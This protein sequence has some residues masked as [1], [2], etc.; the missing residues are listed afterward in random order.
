MRKATQ[1]MMIDRNPGLIY[2]RTFCSHGPVAWI[3]RVSLRV[4]EE[5][6]TYRRH[7]GPLFHVLRSKHGYHFGLNK[8]LR[9]DAFYV[10]NGSAGKRFVWIDCYRV[11]LRD[12]I[13]S[14][15]VDAL[16]RLS[17][18]A[19]LDLGSKD[20]RGRAEELLSNFRPVALEVRVDLSG[21]KEKALC[22]TL[23]RYR[24]GDRFNI[25]PR[26]D[27]RRYDRGYHPNVY[28]KRADWPDV[29]VLRVEMI[30]LARS[31]RDVPLDD[32]LQP[33][34]SVLERFLPVA[35]EKWEKLARGRRPKPEV[36]KIVEVV[37]S[38]TP[39][40]HRASQVHMTDE[41]VERMIIAGEWGK[42]L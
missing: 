40:L 41:E 42:E 33:T 15:F 22:K 31:L 36:E 8:D 10:K 19:V 28:I 17:D 38:S 24:K 13:R 14:A 37:R 21:P 11:P 12:S 5:K 39:L 27:P 16:L 29:H 1:Q 35:L 7:P 23:A 9:P 4:E 20:R 3:D 2:S 32:V 6:F 26:K 30:L 34:S 18:V 25:V